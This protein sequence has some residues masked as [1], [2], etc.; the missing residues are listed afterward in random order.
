MCRLGNNRLISLVHN[1]HIMC[2][3]LSRQDT[4]CCS[5]KEYFYSHF[6][7]CLFLVSY[8][9][10]NDLKQVPKKTLQFLCWPLVAES[11]S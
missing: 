7:V 8:E 2:L 4:L 1:E 6:S 10:L 9:Y 5:L 11:E 3:L